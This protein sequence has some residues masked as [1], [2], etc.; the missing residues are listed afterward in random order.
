[1]QVAVIDIGTNTF[2]IVIVEMLSSTDYHIILELKIPVLL[3]YN[4][5]LKNQISKSA[6]KRAI[7][8]L[9]VFKQ[10]VIDV[11]KPDKV[12]AF[13]TSAFRTALNSKELTQKIEKKTGL[14]I[15]II[16]GKR[17]AKL[18]YYGI[19]QAVELSEKPVLML[20]IGGGSCEFLIANNKKIFLR[21]SYK[22]GVSR[23][24]ELFTLHDPMTE[25]EIIEI[26]NF[27]A[28][29]LKSLINRVLSDNYGT[30]DTLIGSSGSFDSFYQ[31]TV[32]MMPYSSESV[33][34]KL[35]NQIDIDSFTALHQKLLMSTLSE[36][37]RMKGL[38]LTRADLIVVASIIVNFVLKSMSIKKLVQSLYSMKEGMIWEIGSN[39]KQ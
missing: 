7:N 36:R 19:C 1:M 37:K 23:L 13:A 28:K 22:I 18:V 29:K 12:F 4:N 17:E 15:K 3:A 14:T 9:L 31:I 34:I 6:V 10:N 8:A 21:K 25:T 32:N 2:K 20:D 27:L 33:A 38:I 39:L 5:R 30:I 24:M 11:Y 16:S 26:E 35:A